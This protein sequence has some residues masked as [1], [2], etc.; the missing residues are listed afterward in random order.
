[1]PSPPKQEEEEQDE[2]AIDGGSTNA[3]HWADSD[4]EVP[5]EELPTPP[6]IPQ[7]LRLSVIL[8][9]NDGNAID[10]EIAGY[11][12]P[13]PKLDEVADFLWDLEVADEDLDLDSMPQTTV[14][15]AAKRN[16]DDSLGRC[17]KLADPKLPAVSHAQ[18]PYRSFESPRMIVDK[19]ATL[20][21]KISQRISSD[22]DGTILPTPRSPP[23]MGR[24]SR[25]IEVGTK[26]KDV[27]IPALR[28][29]AREEANMSR[30]LT[31]PWRA[32]AVQPGSK[33]AAAESLQIDEVPCIYSFLRKQF[34]DVNL[35]NRRAVTESDL[36]SFVRSRARHMGHVP[37]DFEDLL[38]ESGRRCFQQAAV[39][40]EGI[41]SEDWVHFG[42]LLVSS[43]S[44]PTQLLNRRLRRE[45][46]G[47][48]VFLREAVDAFERAD[49][50]GRGSLHLR[51]I[52]ATFLDCEELLSQVKLAASEE[53][54]Y[55]DFVAFCLGYRRTPVQLNWYDVTRGYA[56]WLPT[57]VLLG[58]NLEG[59]WHT[60]V[61]A[62]G[63]EYWFGGKVLASE[64]GKAPFPPGPI[65]CSDLGTTLHTKEELE[66]WLR[67]EVV[68]R[69][70]RDNYDILSHNCN[71]FSDEV[72]GFLIQGGHIPDEARRQPEA[73]IGT[74]GINAL[75][76]ILN[77]WL[78]GFEAG[79]DRSSE[80]DDLTGE[81]RARLWPGDLCLYAP[82]DGQK[83]KLAQ[84]S[85]VDA[86]SGTCDVCYFDSSSIPHVTGEV[87]ADGQLRHKLCMLAGEFWDW[88]LEYRKAVPL[89]SLRP[90][91]ASGSAFSVRGQSAFAASLG[92][93]ALLRAG[94][95]RID[96][97]IQNVLR[98]KAVVYAHCAQGHPMQQSENQW[99]IAW[100]GSGCC[101]GICRKNLSHVERKLECVLC[102]FY[103]CSS[104]DRKGLFR[105]YYSLGSMA[106]G[107]ARQMLQE[108]S[109]IRYKARRYMSAAGAVNGLL[110]LE[111]W[112]GKLA[113]RL[114][115]DL[116]RDPPDK[117]ELTRI[118]RRHA[119][120]GD[121]S[122]NLTLDEDKFCSLLSELLAVHSFM[123]HL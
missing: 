50:R 122:C 4:A 35:H 117:E 23:V 60:G 80:I 7:R 40:K 59:I 14:L 19:V 76:P 105:G 31:T 48:S 109:W 38:R 81:W 113:M 84:V 15:P 89:T 30:G 94:L 56:K 102:G 96:P 32:E 27:T 92:L 41:R 24:L 69:Y 42:L 74:S 2:L 104:C 114:Y 71:H 52:E 33:A 45:L 46:A 66:D 121:G 53:L 6:R 10:K 34:A 17:R 88:H 95:G 78:G 28:S 119:D 123:Y 82:P 58:Q 62:F 12:P 22:T 73:L 26:F 64:P 37:A 93:G 116:G 21:D 68:P 70:T 111:V 107:T 36:I 77:S 16:H 79:S 55:Y 118:F 65:R 29:T 103:L 20:V 90:H 25:A 108:P 43:P 112:Q 97:G 98:R 100:I 120:A 86:F 110:G 61:L 87:I 54:C 51:D 1:M 3:W 83:V 5:D 75:R 44:A 91:E 47:N 85:S 57:G 8:L 115:G 101:C 67:F 63:R 18:K 106:A 11:R 72:V 13:S 49:S 9:G 39:R 99:S